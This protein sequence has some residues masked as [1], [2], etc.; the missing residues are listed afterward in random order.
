MIWSILGNSVAGTSHSAGTVPC[1]DAF[2]VCAFG[3]AGEWLAIAAADG[4]G[5]ASH[6]EVGAT[7]VC[8]EFVRRL[9]A[10]EP[11]RILTRDGL[12]ALFS[13]VRTALLAAAER[14]GVRSRDVACTSLLSVIGPMS[15]AF[16]QLGD[17][18][19]VIRQGDGY[20]TIFWPEPVDY[21]N[22][23]DFLTDDSFPIALQFETVTD[24]IVEVAV[25]TDGLQRVALDYTARTAYSGFFRPLFNELR[26]ST[27]PESLAAPFQQ[28]LDS[29]R[30]NERTDDDK[31]LVLAV[32]HP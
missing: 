24:S 29:D 21:A 17:G 25:L 15:A 31:T 6:S 27:H 23:T 26:N 11:E 13:D 4:A 7:A 10:L 14:I 18:A 16:A 32:R 5:S 12:V 9:A 30:I 20:R 19:I 1:Q 3:P 28:F 8:A 2:R 22:A